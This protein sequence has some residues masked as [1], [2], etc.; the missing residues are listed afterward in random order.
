[1]YEMCQMYELYEIHEVYEIRETFL[2]PNNVMEPVLLHHTV[3][4]S[5]CK[6]CMQKENTKDTKCMKCMKD[7]N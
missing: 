4:M 2:N 7:M 5:K 3:E 1:M 6:P